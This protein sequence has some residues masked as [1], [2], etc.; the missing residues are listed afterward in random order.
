MRPRTYGIFTVLI[1]AAQIALCFVGPMAFLRKPSLAVFPLRTFGVAHDEIPLLMDFV[2][3]AIAD[4]NSFS[5]VSRR[6]LI[7]HFVKEDPTFDPAMV[8]P[9]DHEEALRV[10][11]DLGLDRF[12]MATV[13]GSRSRYQVTV[14]IRETREARTLRTGRFWSDSLE[15]LLAGIDSAGEPLLLRE[16]LS[17]QTRGIGITDWLILILMGFHMAAGFYA[18]R[19]GRPGRI[20][21]AVWFPTL[22][23]F[24]FAYIHALSANMDYVQRFIASGGGLR[25]ARSTALERTY[26]AVRFGPLL[27]LGAVAYTKDR[28]KTT[29]LEAAGGGAISRLAAHWALPAVLLSALMFG[30]SFPSFV[31]L[32]GLGWL[33]WFALVPILLVIKGSRPRR[34]VFYGV[35]F[36]TLQALI[37]NFWHGTFSYLTLHVMTVGFVLQFLVFMLVLVPLIQRSG[38]WGFLLVPTAWVA[39]DYLRS[40]GVLGYPWGLIGTAPYRFLPLIQIASLTGVWGVE[41]IVILSSAGIAWALDTVPLGRSRLRHDWWRYSAMADARPPLVTLSAVLVL[42]VVTG[43]AMLA[44]LDARLADNQTVR[45]A[46]LVLIQQNT[47]PRKHEYREHL[48]KLYAITDEALAG[49]DEPPDLVVWPEG[50]FP[51]DIRYSLRPDM[52]NSSWA[53]LTQEFFA[54]QAGINTWLVA[55]DQ[56]HIVIPL[57]DGSEQIRNFNSSALL[58]PDNQLVAIYHKRQLVPFTEHFPLDRERFPRLYELF[59]TFDASDW[60]RGSELLIFEH[61]RMRFFTPICFEDLFPDQVRQFVLKGADVIVNMSN[62]YW[63]LTPVEGVQHGLHALFR[64]VENRR[65][66]VRSTVSGYTMAVDAAG[67]IAP[68]SPAPYTEG[69]LVA[70]VLLPERWLTPYTRYGDWLPVLCVILTGVSRLGLAGLRFANRRARRNRT[71][72]RAGGPDGIAL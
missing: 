51:V 27:L 8:A 2:E 11:R 35:A 31:S 54:Y 44:R 22:V 56:D 29:T 63:S 41:F 17:I 39:F 62:D 70:R 13:Y 60:E 71:L 42:S 72:A 61:D 47:D 10:S 57:E 37:V 6:F 1:A 45:S 20:V 49:L 69:F 43:W 33:S 40:I 26:T 67:R 53:R 55:G 52:A 19:G 4:T 50:G 7:D 3:R 28:L 24:I 21:E 32:Y 23:L 12:A 25:L 18:L 59:R 68:A 16:S 15:N 64:A 46:V 14:N 38:R 36:G 48:A 30:L 34:A 5:L 65:P 9:V 66:L 58:S